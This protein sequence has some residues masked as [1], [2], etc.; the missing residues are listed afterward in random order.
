MKLAVCEAPAA[1]VVGDAGWDR[2]VELTKSTEPDILLL[3]EM[4]F[5]TWVSVGRERDAAILRANQ[6]QHLEGIDRLAELSA[7]TILGTYPVFEASLSVNRAFVWTA[8]TGITQ[9][10][11]KQFFPNEGGFYEARWFERGKK[12]FGITEAGGVG[13][14]FL[15]CT[16]VM[17]NEWARYYGRNGAHLIAVPRATPVGSEERWQTMCSAAAIVS[18]C[19]VASSNRRGVGESGLEFAGKGWIFNPVGEV[20][21]ETSPEE[22][23]VTAELD[24][25]SVLKAQGEYPC[26]VEELEKGEEGSVC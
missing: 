7:G 17:F 18:G 19:Y 22:P 3:N 25:T 11:T 5:G 24:L 9:V 26:Y 4:P 8:P 14:G 12:K 10:H 2:L 15:I 1:L 13:V 20:I 6:R 23:V 16:D 21:A